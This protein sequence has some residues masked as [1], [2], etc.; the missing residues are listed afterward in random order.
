[1]TAVKSILFALA[2]GLLGCKDDDGSSGGFDAG[3][4]AVDAGGAFGD[5][6]SG[7]CDCIPGRCHEFGS[8]GQRCTMTCS[9]DD[10]CPEG[11]QGRRCNNMGVC[12]P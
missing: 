4:C 12:R 9:S 10:Q 5:T 7:D 3:G 1:M 2:L 6:C 8:I 11:S